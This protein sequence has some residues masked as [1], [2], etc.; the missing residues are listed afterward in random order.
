MRDWRRW[1]ASALLAL[2]S[3]S[4]R[5][6][7]QSPEMTRAGELL[8][9]SKWVEAEAAYR[10]IIAREDGNGAAWSNLGESLLQQHK[11][12]EA[13]EAF[14]KAIAAGFRPV[15]NQINVARVYGDAKDKPK[16]LAELQKVVASGAG[17][18]MR[19][20]VL[21]SAEFASLKGDSDFQKLLDA[22]LPCRTP[23]YHQFDFWIG[24]WDVYA[25][26]SGPL[27]GHNSVTAEQDGCLLVEHWTASSGG[28]TGTSFNYYDVRDRKWHQVYI[29]NSGNA[30]AFPA[31]AGN[32]AQGK[33]VLLTDRETKPL[34]RWT[35]YVLEPGKVR[36][37][38]EQSSDGGK[39][40]AIT[41][42][43]V[44]VKAGSAKARN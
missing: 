16:V 4:T 41:W 6:T 42:D 14:E 24:Q 17:G 8:N 43:S 18:Q 35:W 32:L 15:L 3:F 12:P 38:A 36:Q 44:Y 39:T 25:P 27:V 9:A 20:L 34:S 40:W 30:G 13:I 22:M 21:S 23:E 2:V 5:A 33:M 31:M 19:P 10:T 11:R 26:D 28:Q 7:Q 29:D 1:R 37:M